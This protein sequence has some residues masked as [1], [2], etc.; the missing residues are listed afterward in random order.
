[1]LRRISDLKRQK[2]KACCKK[3]GASLL[4]L[5]TKYYNDDEFKEVRWAGY[6]AHTGRGEKCMQNFSQKI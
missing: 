1:V 5:F 4:V 2:I 3:S 6:V